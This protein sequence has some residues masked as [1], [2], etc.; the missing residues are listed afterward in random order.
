MFFTRGMAIGL[1]ML[2]AGSAF[3]QVSETEGTRQMYYLATPAPATVPPLP[4]GNSAPP[5]SAN[6]AT[7]HLG[8]RYNLLLVNE[9]TK[10]DQ[11]ISPDRVLSEGDCFAIE[12]QANRSGY[13]YVLAKQSSGTW[14]PLSDMPG[15]HEAI[16]Q[17]KTVRIPSQS[18]FVIHNPPG[19][20]TMFVVLSRDPRDFFELYED[21]KEKETA[22][23]SSNSQAQMAS[24]AKLNAAVAH[25][26]EQFGGTRDITIAKVTE[27]QSADEP[28]GAVYVVSKKTSSSIVTKIEVR[29]K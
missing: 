6:A 3:A 15:Q 20:E 1:G 23:G 17:S 26:D 12:L 4:H 18:C 21:V 16:L 10:K 25:L 14:T 28:R 22:P 9:K 11:Q 27:P 13:L 2:L 7:P 24:N 29:H 5:A 19:K 8:I